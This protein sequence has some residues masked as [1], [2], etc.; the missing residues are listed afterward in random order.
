MKTGK[1]LRFAEAEREIYK[2]QRDGVLQTCVRIAAQRDQLLEAIEEHRKEKAHGGT[3]NMELVDDRLYELADQIKG[4]DASAESLREGS[5][6][7]THATRG[8]SDQVD[9]VAP[10]QSSGNPYVRSPVIEAAIER[11]E[12][13]EK[14]AAK[15]L[16][17]LTAERDP[18]GTSRGALLRYTEKLIYRDAILIVADADYERH[19]LTTPEVVEAFHQLQANEET[20][21]FAEHVLRDRFPDDI[22]EQVERAWDGANEE[23]A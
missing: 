21:S 18:M 23:K 10:E 1:K 16:A 6:T 7:S 20:G 12:E 19:V 2:E 15:R 4:G 14:E 8:G 17:E 3:A 11:L 13:R 9:G 22:E 5:G